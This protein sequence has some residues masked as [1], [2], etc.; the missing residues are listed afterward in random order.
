[1]ISCQEDDID[2]EEMT[3]VTER[4]KRKVENQSQPVE[5]LTGPCTTDSQ[6]CWMCQC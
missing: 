4:R 5:S 1:M 3:Y 6:R 2:D